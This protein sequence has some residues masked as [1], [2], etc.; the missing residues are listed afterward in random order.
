MAQSELEKRLISLIKDEKVII[1]LSKHNITT[2]CFVM[3][4]ELFNFIIENYSKY[5]TVPSVTTIKNQFPE[6]EY[7]ADTDPKEF[8]FFCDEL[9]KSNTQRRAIQIIN[10]ASDTITSDPYGTI[11][12]LVHK[13]STIRKPVKISKSMTDKDSLKRLEMVTK[14]RESIKSGVTIGIK[15]GINIFDNKYYGWQPGNYIAVVGRL[16]IGKS[17]LLEY[18]ACA[19]YND[20]RKVLY[21]SPEMSINEV[22]LRWDTLMGTMRGYRFQNDKLGTGEVDL[23]KYKEWLTKASQR[24]DWITYDSNSGRSFTVNS[25]AQMV[26]EFQPDLV[27][28]DGIALVDGPGDALWSKVRDISRGLKAI[29]QNNKLVMMVTAQANREAGDKMPT[30]SQISYSDSVAQDADVVIPMNQ[31]VDR[32]MERYITLPKRR[33]AKAINTRLTLQFNVNEGLITI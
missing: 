22:E 29:A 25:I 27:A 14:N 21:I 23:N 26:D 24:N 28:V 12:N 10:Q 18:F 8:K 17:W 20:N 30:T 7:Y 1:E 19:A 3:Y 32:P 5:K 4:P 9:L 15:T 33:S 16:G 13:L 2:D 6:F 11:D 31:D